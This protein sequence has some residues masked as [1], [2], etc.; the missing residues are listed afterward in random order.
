M[1]FDPRTLDSAKFVRGIARAMAQ[2]SIDS[3][4]RDQLLDDATTTLR[5]SGVHIPDGIRVNVVAD[6]SQ[7]VTADPHTVVLDLKSHMN[8]GDISLNE[9]A[10]ASVA[11]GG[12]CQSTASTAYTVASCVSSTSSA[13]TAC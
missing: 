3:V 1:P 2:A 8:I 7:H 5:E 10:L 6:A 11:G 4:Y 9:E 13:S 12:S